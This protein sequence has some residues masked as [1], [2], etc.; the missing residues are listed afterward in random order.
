M[1]VEACLD[2]P[3]EDIDFI[4][5]GNVKE[6]LNKLTITMHSIIESAHQGKLLR[7]GIDVVLVGQPNVG[8]SSLLNQLAGEER[9]I[10][11]EIAG[12]TR[13]S[14]STHM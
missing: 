11:T 1:Y 8:K 5:Q 2:F 3:E 14:I 6:K 9:A 4:T 12:T 10:V 13:D 7:E